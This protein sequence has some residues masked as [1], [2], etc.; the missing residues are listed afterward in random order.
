[1]EIWKKKIEQSDILDDEFD[2]F[3]PDGKCT[4]KIIG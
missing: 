2:E 4:L 1:M 3:A